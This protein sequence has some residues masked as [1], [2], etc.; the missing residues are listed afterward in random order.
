MLIK[1]L[2]DKGL[3]YTPATYERII[4]FLCTQSKDV[5]ERDAFTCLEDL[6]SE[7][8]R[9]IQLA[10]RSA[11]VNP[12]ASSPAQPIFGPTYRTYHVMLRRCA[13]ERD[14]RALKLQEDM[15]AFGFTPSADLVLELERA[16]LW[17]GIRRQ[18]AA[19]PEYGLGIDERGRQIGAPPKPP[20]PS[21]IQ[22]GH[23]P[24][25]ED[26]NIPPH[27]RDA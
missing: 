18:S 9:K 27:V 2:D 25:S 15:R 8:K 6:V 1:S 22:L 3:A 4:A 7:T 17:T 16:R 13:H 24:L 14:A 21:S 23:L 5:W 10:R 12:A 11:L 20:R 26:G 19:G